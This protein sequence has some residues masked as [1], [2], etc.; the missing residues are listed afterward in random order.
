V[1]A[2]APLD[3]K[4]KDFFRVVV[5]CPFIEGYGQTENLGATFFTE[6]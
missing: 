5:G 4:V 2:S 3:E 6:V 1:C